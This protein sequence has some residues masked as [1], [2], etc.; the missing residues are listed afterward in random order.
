MQHQ[1]AE[2]KGLNI[3][4]DFSVD[5]GTFTVSVPEEF[6]EA[7]RKYPHINWNEV[8]KQGILKRLS[9]LKKFEELKRKG[10]I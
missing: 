10:A 9:E 5:M 4:T 3:C 1:K 2:G 6:L 7:K 8:L